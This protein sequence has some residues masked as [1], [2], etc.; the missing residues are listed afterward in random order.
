MNLFR[1][2]RFDQTNL[3]RSTYR[4]FHPGIKF[5]NFNRRSSEYSFLPLAQPPALV[6]R[7]REREKA[8]RRA[9]T[10]HPQS[11]IKTPNKFYSIHN[12]RNLQRSRRRRGL[13]NCSVVQWVVAVTVMLDHQQKTLGFTL[14]SPYFLNGNPSL[15]PTR[16]LFPFKIYQFSCYYSF[17]VSAINLVQ[18][19][20]FRISE[21]KLISWVFISFCIC[22]YGKWYLGNKVLWSGETVW[23]FLR[24]NS[25]F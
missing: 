23:W 19:F 8:L 15:T 24:L 12:H 1:P 4:I 20:N 14:T 13:L 18:F 17:H 7:E 9:I 3:I 10:V 21:N 6:N 5:S 25:V 2:F 16:F 11:Q 22:F